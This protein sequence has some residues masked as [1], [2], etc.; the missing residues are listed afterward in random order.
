[1][2]CH[3]AV[4]DFTP[5]LISRGGSSRRSL[6]EGRKSESESFEASSFK[7]NQKALSRTEGRFAAAHSIYAIMRD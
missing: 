4:D 3:L 2:D 7:G 6:G 5:S 1:M